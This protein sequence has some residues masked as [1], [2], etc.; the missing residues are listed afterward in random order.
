MSCQVFQC[1]ESESQYV[2]D[3]I[4]KEQR[5]EPPFEFFGVYVEVEFFCVE[6][7]QVTGDSKE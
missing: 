7:E 3:E 6:K 4:G 5:I 2:P 1:I